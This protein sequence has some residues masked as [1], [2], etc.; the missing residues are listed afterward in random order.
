MGDRRFGL[1]VENKSNLSVT[2][3]VFADVVCHVYNYGG[4]N[5]NWLADNSDKACF[6]STVIGFE[7]YVRR[8][9]YGKYSERHKALTWLVENGYLFCHA[10]KLIKEWVGKYRCNRKLVNWYGIT[11]KGWE[12]AHLYIQE[13]ERP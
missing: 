10:N 12:V 8:N 5:S 4:I 3:N 2:G 13:T 6:G 1:W 7:E 11:K 9:G